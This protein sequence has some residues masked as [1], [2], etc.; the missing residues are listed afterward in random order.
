MRPIATD[1]ARGVVC[2]SVYLC[3]LVALS[4]FCKHDLTDRDDVWGLTYVAP[5]N[6][7]LDG[8]QIPHRKGHF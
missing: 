5:R 6:H 4:E 3:V 2:V 1:V 7:V 8:V